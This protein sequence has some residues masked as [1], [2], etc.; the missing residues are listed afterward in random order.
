MPVSRGGWKPGSQG[1]RGRQTGIRR[2]YRILDCRCVQVV[3]GHVRPRRMRGPVAASRR[4]SSRSGGRSPGDRFDSQAASSQ[5]SASATLRVR[6]P[7]EFADGL[8]DRIRVA[9]AAQVL[10]T[11]RQPDR[12]PP[13]GH[14]GKASPVSLAVIDATL[15]TGGLSSLPQLGQRP[16]ATLQPVNIFGVDLKIS[17]LHYCGVEPLYH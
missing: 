12:A 10:L 4:R 15:P 2:G 13:A 17:L 7:R 14:E 5:A 9:R 11:R 3:Q 1:A 6:R 16:R 8:D